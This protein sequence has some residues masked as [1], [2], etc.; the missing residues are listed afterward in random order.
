MSSDEQRVDTD[1][2]RQSLNAALAKI[3]HANGHACPSG[4]GNTDQYMHEF[5]AASVGNSYFNGRREHAKRDLSRFVID[6]GKL[7]DLARDV[8]K[9]NTPASAVVG[10]SKVYQL[11]VS[12]T[13]PIKRLDISSLKSA[14]QLKFK[15]TAEDVEELIGIATVKDAPRQQFTVVGK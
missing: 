11:H 3:G 1:K 2:V 4:V 13:R 14:L 6:A 10:S 5:F 12:L 8:I 9:T 15:M 7:D